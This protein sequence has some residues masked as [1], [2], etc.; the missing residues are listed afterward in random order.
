MGLQ[1]WMIKSWPIINWF[2]STKDDEWP[3]FVHMST[4]LGQERQGSRPCV[5]S[6]VWVSSINGVYAGLAWEWVEFR[7]GVLMLADPNSIITNLR[8]AD[9]VG[10]E[11]AAL[12]A[13]VCLNR[14]LHRLAWQDSV[15]EI[16]AAARSAQGVIAVPKVNVAQNDAPMRAARAA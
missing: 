12:T 4:Q 3:T 6:T 7:P 5:G 10:H 16:V 2:P 14:I 15:K 9:A 11:C 8:V 1:S 13:S